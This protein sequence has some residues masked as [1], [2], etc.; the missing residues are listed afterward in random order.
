MANSLPHEAT[1]LPAHVIVMGVSGSGKSTI[2]ALIA[3]RLGV[4][5][6]DG[7]S[8]HP[9]E[10]IRKMAGGTPLNDDERAPWLKAVGHALADAADG[11]VI[12]CSALKVGYRDIIR[13]EQPDAVFVH[14]SGSA[15]VLTSRLEGRSDHF[16][17]K[18]LLE[19]QLSTL[20]PLAASERGVVVDIASP[21]DAVVDEAVAGITT[22]I[23]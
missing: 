20:E 23:R 14:L 7:D 13:T 15:D 18:S 9:I 11:L 19:S 16:M 1:G 21:V 8:L 6:I 4:P 22:H 17:P 3:E 10:N 12:A 2:G 5:F